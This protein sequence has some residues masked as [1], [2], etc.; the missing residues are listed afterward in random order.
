MGLTVVFLFF[1]SIYQE[2]KQKISIDN[3][4]AFLFKKERYIRLEFVRENSIQLIAK[5][6]RENRIL[7][8][9]W[10]AY[11]VVYR[12]SVSCDDYQMLRS[13]AAQQILLRRSKEAKKR[14]N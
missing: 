1:R 6:H 9:I 11:K 2:P 3:Q 7:D 4:D 14:Y 13:F 12:D 5:V 8:W 10:P